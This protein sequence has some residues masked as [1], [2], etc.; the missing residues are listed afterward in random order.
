MDQTEDPK[1]VQLVEQQAARREQPVADPGHAALAKPAVVRVRQGGRCRHPR[2]EHPVLEQS[3]KPQR[4]AN[5]AH[6]SVP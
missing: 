4:L 6:S 5:L 3:Q 1:A 2:R